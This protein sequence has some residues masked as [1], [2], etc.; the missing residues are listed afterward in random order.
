MSSLER[1]TNDSLRERKKAGRKFSVLT[2]YDAPT[3]RLME[4]AGVEVLLVGDTAGE[5]V[6]GLPS[7]REIPVDYL[8]TITA[9]VRRG[10]PRAYVMADLPYACRLHGEE[11]LVRWAR[12][13]VDETGCDGVKVEVQ[14]GEAPLIRAMAQLGVPVIAHLGLLPQYIDPTVGYRAQARDAAG[15]LALMRTAREMEEAGAVGLLLEAVASEVAGRIT[16]AS[17]VPVIGCVAGPHCDGT[18]V[19]LH[20]MVAWGGGHP[21]RAVKQYVNLAEV[22]ERAF[23]EYVRDIHEGA[24]PVEADSIHMRPGELEKLTAELG[25]A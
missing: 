5:V 23:A 10:A 6:L 21:P 7:T 22:L 16:A 13:F 1:I 2:C 24:F 15:A 18:V 17:S 11:E 9:A 19:V 3:A 12:R 4:Q 8:L 25:E 14:A 20:D